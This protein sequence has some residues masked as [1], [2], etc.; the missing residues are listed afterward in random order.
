MTSSTQ[1]ASDLLFPRKVATERPALRVMAVVG[2]LGVVF[3]DIATSPLYALQDC[4]AGPHGVAPRPSNVFGAISLIVWS[5]FVVVTVKYLAVLMR[6]DNK[7]EGGIMALLALLPRASRERAPGKLGVTTILVIGG[8]ALLFGDGIITP[9]ISVLSAVE[10]LEVVAPRLE[11]VVVPVTIAILIGLFAVQRR[12]SG[13]LGNWFGPI[14]ILWLTTAMILGVIHIA[15]RPEIV[16][17]LSPHHAVLFFRDEGFHAFRVLGGVVLSVT[18]AEALYADMGHFG[19]RPIQLGW[20]FVVLPALVLNY[21]GQGALI[22]GNPELAKQPFYA[23]VPSGSWGYPFVVL[24]TVATIIASQALITGVFSLVRQSIQLGYFPR[25]R[26]EHTAMESAGQIYVPFMN[27]FLGISCVLLV[28]FFERSNK[29][30]AAYG[31]A[32]S[33]TMTITSIAFFRVARSHFEWSTAKAAA[34]VGAFLVFDVAFLGANML[35][36]FDG[37]YVPLLVGSAFLIVMVVWARG[38][39]FLGAYFRARSEPTEAFLRSLPAQLHAR[40]RGIGVVMTASPESIPPVLLRIV[41]RFRTLQETVLLTTVVTEETPY[42]Y[43]ERATVNAIGAGLHRVVIRF[44]FMETPQI[45]PT[46]AAIAA[47]IDPRAKPE[48][49][50][51]VLGLERFLGGRGGQMGATAEKLFSFLSR[52]AYNPTDYYGV[53]AGQVVELGARIDL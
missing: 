49:L 23:L 46:L 9:A 48:D 27:W 22:L 53:P 40:T 43:G 35:K 37:G 41:G 28:L 26:I 2:A 7:G 52:N 34:V 17:A 31:L 19:R 13:G 29:L 47:G 36:I 39:S 24:G 10:G 32:V 45:H 42:V 1:P 30:A 16:T 18:G 4:L 50:T 20:L 8:A 11:V 5:L 51:Y 25:L 38:R 14:M 33:G 12:G 21:L 6:A 15:D 44:G 3:G